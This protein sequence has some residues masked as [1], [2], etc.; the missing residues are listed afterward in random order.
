VPFHNREPVV[1]KSNGNAVSQDQ[2]LAE[3]MMGDHSAQVMAGVYFLR[4]SSKYDRND[5]HGAIADYSNALRLKED[6]WTYY[7]RGEAY[8][9]VNKR[10]EALADFKAALNLGIRVPQNYLDMCQ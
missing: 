2:S 1:I 3:N 10:I 9:K 6:A 4:A 5:L 7:I 8:L